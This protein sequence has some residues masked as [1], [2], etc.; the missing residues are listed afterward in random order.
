MIEREKHLHLLEITDAYEV[1]AGAPD[2]PVFL[3]CEHASDRLP[4]GWSWPEADRRL[5]GTHW[6]WDP[7]AAE[8]T[9][10]LAAALRAP[11]V[12]S[13]FTRL[14]ADPNRPEDAETLFRAEADGAPVELNRRIDEAERARRLERFHRP[15]HAAIDRHLA[16]HRGGIVFSIHTF[17]PVYEGTRREVEVGVLFDTQEALAERAAEAIR[18]AGF[19]TALNEPWSGRAGLIY[20]AERHAGAHGRRALELEV[21]Q[22]LAARPE[23]RARLVEVL[24]RFFAP[25]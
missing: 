17:T 24:A 15:Y 11:A 4:A 9:R 21:R 16:A 23:V 3:T 14:L 13:R 8:I 7:G 22:D 12:L 10:A 5:S 6:A 25:R 1:I 18:A 2:A 20:A 19:R